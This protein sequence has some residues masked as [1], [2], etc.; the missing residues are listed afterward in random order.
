[1]EELKNQINETVNKM[2]NETLLKMILSFVQ[3]LHTKST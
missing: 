1:M 2:E 3:R